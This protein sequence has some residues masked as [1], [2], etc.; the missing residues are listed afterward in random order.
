MANLLWSKPK[1]KSELQKFLE[2]NKRRKEKYKRITNKRRG[3]TVTEPVYEIK[4]P[5]ELLKTTP[6]ETQKSPLE[7]IIKNFINQWTKN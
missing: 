1:P 2:E 3:L 6:I 7:K 4:M 5:N